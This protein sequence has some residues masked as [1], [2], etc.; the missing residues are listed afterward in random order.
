LV[1]GLVAVSHIHSRHN[2]KAIDRPS[3]QD[4]A[5]SLRELFFEGF[6]RTFAFRDERTKRLVHNNPSGF[7][8]DCSSFR[9]PE[10]S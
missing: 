3:D 7:G 8:T 4:S 6:E 5:A 9:H 1:L 10:N 2:A